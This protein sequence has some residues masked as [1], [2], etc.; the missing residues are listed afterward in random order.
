MTKDVLL[1]KI[2][3]AIDDAMHG[4]LYGKIEVEFRAGRPTF[5]RQAK[6]DKLDTETET[7]SNG[8]QYR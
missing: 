3:A 1:K 6:E 5:L 4:R 7:R 2:D 8:N